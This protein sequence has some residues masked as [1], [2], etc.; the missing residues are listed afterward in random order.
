MSTL[1]NEF[2]AMTNASFFAKTNLAIIL[3]FVYYLP[4]RDL[5]TYNYAV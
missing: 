5:W 3:S 4:D 2:A 1:K